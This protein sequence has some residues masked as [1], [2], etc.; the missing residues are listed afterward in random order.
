MCKRRWAI[1]HYLER[2]LGTLSD[3]ALERL[4][5]RLANLVATA[6]F[7]QIRPALPFS[8]LAVAGRCIRCRGTLLL[9]YERPLGRVGAFRSSAIDHELVH[10]L[11]ELLDGAI[12]RESWGRVPGWR[13]YWIEWNAL[14]FGSTLIAVPVIC[15]F[16]YVVVTAMAA[17]ILQ[18]R[19]RMAW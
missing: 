3:R 10:C 13:K 1:E 18:V 7:E 15:G 14:L 9:G 5:C 12:T 17:I 16:A 19:F 2:D 11:Q 4:N 6:R 8:F